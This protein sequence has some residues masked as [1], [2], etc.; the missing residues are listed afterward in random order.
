MDKRIGKG[1]VMH[2]LEKREEKCKFLAKLKNIINLLE[3]EAVYS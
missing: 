1:E 2:M 3:N